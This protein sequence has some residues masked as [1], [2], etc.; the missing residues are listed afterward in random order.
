MPVTIE[1]VLALLP[2]LFPGIQQVPLANI[3]QLPDNPGGTPSEEVILGLMES[4]REND[5]QNPLKLKPNRTQPLA[6]GVQI[7]PENPRITLEGRPWRVEDF[8]Y[9]VFS[10]NRRLIAL[11]RLQK[12]K[13]PCYI[14]NPSELE[15]VV[16]GRIDN[17][18]DQRGWWV[19]YQDVERVIKA[20]PY[21]TQRQIKG[22]LGLDDEKINRAI[23]VL[24]LLNSQSR[25]LIARDTSILNKGIPGI[26][27][28]AISQLAALGPGT[29]LKPG[30]PKKDMAEGEEPQ[31]LYPHPPGDPRP[32]LPGPPGSLSP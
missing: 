32:R 24:P 13:A 29:G 26:S 4:I 12:D 31:K 28:L 20:N 19:D 21:V 1:D 3:S 23:K 2:E 22:Y 5:L 17:V 27:D 7:H 9:W 18:V 10:G 8:H 6:E 14:T 25:D 11:N 15:T 16:K 30:R